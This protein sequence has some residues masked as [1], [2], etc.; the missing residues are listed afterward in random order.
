[1]GDATETSRSCR[2]QESV[3][4]FATYEGVPATTHR[5]QTQ[6]DVITP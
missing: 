4:T 2:F 1:M 3:Y 5:Q 6:T